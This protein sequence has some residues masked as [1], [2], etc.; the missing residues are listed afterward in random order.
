MPPI[1]LG[2]LARFACFACLAP[3]LCWLRFRCFA[4]LGCAGCVGCVVGGSFSLRMIATKRKGGL[5]GSSSLCSWVC[6]AFANCSRASCKNCSFV[7][8]VVVVIALLFLVYG[9]KVCT[10]SCI[11]FRFYIKPQPFALKV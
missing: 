8:V 7:V 9:A 5:F 10:K 2:L 1:F 11:S 6:Y 3:V 4:C